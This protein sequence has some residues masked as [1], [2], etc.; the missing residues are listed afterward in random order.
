VEDKLEIG[1]SARLQCR[2]SVRRIAA[3][4]VRI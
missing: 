1:A 3:A 2:I 4:A